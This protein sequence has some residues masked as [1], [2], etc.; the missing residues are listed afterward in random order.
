VAQELGRGSTNPEHFRNPRRNDLVFAGEPQTSQAAFILVLWVILARLPSEHHVINK[1]LTRLLCLPLVKVCNAK[2]IQIE[3]LVTTQTSL[4]KGKWR[5]SSCSEDCA[6]APFASQRNVC[7]SSL[8]C[9]R[10][11]TKAL[12]NGMISS[13][14]RSKFI[15]CDTR[16]LTLSPMVVSQQ[17]H[18]AAFSRLT[19]Y[20]FSH[21]RDNRQQE[22]LCGVSR[23]HQACL[24]RCQR[25][26]VRHQPSSECRPRL[27]RIFPQAIRLADP[28]GSQKG[29][30][31]RSLTVFAWEIRTICVPLGSRRVGCNAS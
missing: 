14:R 29:G 9:Q 11:P 16:A 28:S 26:I 24:E 27:R 19:L 6:R 30:A 10:A 3:M 13:L 31:A 20:G 2:P 8:T 4:A 22:I 1:F 18:G 25:R 21:T 5:R 23:H 15:N 7:G 12:H 17:P